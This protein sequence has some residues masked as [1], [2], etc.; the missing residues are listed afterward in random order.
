[1]Y[2]RKSGV[3]SEVLG[4]GIGGSFA[5]EAEKKTR[6]WPL[7][8]ETEGGPRVPRLG[9]ASPAAHPAQSRGD[10]AWQAEDRQGRQMGAEGERLKS[11]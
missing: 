2:Q 3:G 1:M 11:D 4:V 9:M 10:L 8:C 5:E 7:L 6:L